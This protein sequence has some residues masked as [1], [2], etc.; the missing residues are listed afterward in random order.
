[1]CNKFITFFISMCLGLPV[2]TA[3]TDYDFNEC[4]GSS[5]P[6]VDPTCIINTPDSLTAVMINHV[7]RHGSRYPS[8]GKHA[9]AVKRLLK[10]AS[11]KRTI[12][13]KGIRL[14]ALAE[15]VIDKSTGRWG[16]LDT[17]GKTEQRWLAARMMGAFP[18][19][20]NNTRINAISSYVPRCIM[21][22]YE[23]TH[24]LSRQNNRLEINTSSGRQHNELM[25][26]FENNEEYEA[27]TGSDIFK[28]TVV[29][30]EDSLL[31][32]RL[33]TKF[34]GSG[35]DTDSID[36]NGS[37]LAVYSLL[38]G[39]AAM[40]L[41]CRISDYVSREE[42]NALWGAFNFRQYMNHSA[43][44]LSDIPAEISK[45]LLLNLIE[46]TDRMI[47]GESLAPVQLRFGHA[48]TL[49]PLLA[50]IHLPGCRYITED[51]A[52][53]GANWKDFDIVPMAA[54]FR[55]ILFKS[56][57]GNYY[58][59]ADLNETPVP[60]CDGWDLYVPWEDAKAYLMLR[61]GLF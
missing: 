59:R 1:M 20:F 58:V 60:L 21:S 51:Y 16:A 27:L 11:A 26:F 24:Q 54:N 9:I 2:I 33:I 22:M 38:A 31:P 29:E 17:L 36:V 19:L 61:A 32:R 14:L 10:D 52:T 53:V 46:T 15:E 44:A 12:T 8:S 5:R 30:W 55:L 6:Y 40:E 4:L 41:P 49:M 7:G 42:F 57:R 25:R 28:S 50:L 37:L 48:E 56:K 18:R 45:P 23:F 47:A 13:G 35:Y 34:V 39:T 3:Q 43:S